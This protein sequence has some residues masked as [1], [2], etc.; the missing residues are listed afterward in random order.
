MHLKQFLVFAIVLS[1]TF[2]SVSASSCRIICCRRC[3]CPTEAKQVLIEVEDE[4][5]TPPIIL[6][7]ERESM[8][9]LEELWTKFQEKK[10]K[11]QDLFKFDIVKM[12]K[13]RLSSN[14]CNIFP[15]IF[16]YFFIVCDLHSKL[17][18]VKGHVFHLGQ[19]T[20]IAEGMQIRNFAPLEGSNEH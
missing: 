1:I 15:P 19:I 13:S 12:Q 20:A 10:L 9:G 3:M 18:S 7:T 6:P 14:P 2:A 4:L 17:Y 8:T 16:L 5:V 11:N